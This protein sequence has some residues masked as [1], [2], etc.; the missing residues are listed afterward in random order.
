MNAADHDRLM[1]RAAT[2]AESDPFFVAWALA[3]YREL[4]ELD[5]AA[6]AAR[7]G[8]S[9]AALRRLALCRRPDGESA[10]FADEVTRIA[11]HTGCDPARLAQVL[12]AAENAERMRRTAS[13]TLLAARDREREEG[14]SDEDG[15]AEE[16]H[17]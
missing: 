3:V 1:A 9:V 13:V 12:R 7:L 5:S 8:C 2:R 17:P 6:L 15:G 16:P 14:P 10:M 11:E 4:A